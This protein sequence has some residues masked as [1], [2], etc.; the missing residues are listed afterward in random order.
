MGGLIVK[1][2][3]TDLRRLEE[4]LRADMDVLLER[5]AKL[6]AEVKELR[7]AVREAVRK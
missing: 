2:D 3:M 1:A 6:E 7:E 4:R 5:I